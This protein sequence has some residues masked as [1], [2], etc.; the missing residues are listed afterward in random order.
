MT[1]KVNLAGTRLV[2]FERLDNSGE[3]RA[4]CGQILV[5]VAKWRWIAAFQG[6][7]GEAEA[8]LWILT[9]DGCLVYEFSCSNF[10]P[11]WRYYPLIEIACIIMCTF[12]G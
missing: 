5:V 11:A 12:L 8:L 3:C 1:K 7:L 10:G 2:D 6:L 4:Q 9:M